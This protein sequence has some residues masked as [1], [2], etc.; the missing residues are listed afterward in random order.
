MI[1]YTCPTCEAKLEFADSQ[2][3]TQAK[4]IGCGHGV[5]VPRSTIAV[6][7]RRKKNKM[8]TGQVVKGYAQFGL[9][10]WELWIASKFRK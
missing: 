2:S 10:L 4:C 9:G 5:F 8:N 1:R 3:N 7:Q 6:G